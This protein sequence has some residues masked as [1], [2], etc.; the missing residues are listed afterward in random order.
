MRRIASVVL[1]SLVAVVAVAPGTSLAQDAPVTGGRL[2]LV[3][4]GDLATLDTAQSV[5]TIDYNATAGLLYEGLYHFTPDGTLEPGLATGMPE[6][7]EDGLTYTFTIK[8]D[9]MFAGPDFTPR[10]VTAADVA[11]GLTRAVDPNLKPAPSW[12]GGYLAGIQ[13]VAEFQAGEADSVSGIEV[14]DDQ[15]LKVTLTAPSVTFLY[16][17]TIGTSWPVPREAVEER[18]EDFANRP[19]GAGPFQLKAWNKGSDITFVRNP[20]YADPAL[21]YLDEIRVSLN[22]DENTQVLRLQ[23]GEADGVFE[24]LGI[25]PASLRLLQSDPNLTVAPSVGPRIYYLALENGG[26]FAN[27][28]LRLAVAHAVT[29]SFLNQFGELAKPWNQLVGS[30]TVQSDPDGTRTYPYDPEK[31]KAYMASGGYDGTPVKI[32]YDVTD[33][34]QSANSTALKQ[35]LEAVGFTV[36]LQGLQSAEFFS[37]VYDPTVRD[38]SSTYWSADY[39]DAQDYFSTNFICGS[40]LNISHFCDESIDAD[41][42]ATET[43]PFGAERDAALR[44]VQQRYIDEVAGIPVMEI[45]PQVV[46][47][48]RVGDIPTLATYAPYDWKRAWARP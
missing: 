40:F 32:I 28:D 19:V 48:P 36:D 2:E 44:A 23:S 21:P 5:T 15:T 33:P 6:I 16:G 43:M 41:L 24:A 10:A 1:A 17:L 9:A 39:P 7:S 31:A 14:V 11:Y 47:G 13:G 29:T 4:G 12:G 25:S 34:Y 18:G 38:I 30:T 35:D 42:M 37:V 8:P 22:T 26:M 20:G 3:A 45:T 46:W 27:K